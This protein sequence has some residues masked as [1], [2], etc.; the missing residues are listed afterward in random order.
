MIFCCFVGPF[1]DHR[2]E[3]LAKE[4]MQR[5]CKLW[6]IRCLDL[7]QNPRRLADFW[8]DAGRKGLRVSLDPGGLNLDSTAFSKWV[9]KAPHDL[10]FFLWGEKGPDFPLEGAFQSISL[11]P[12]TTSHELARVFFLEQ[13]YRA[14][15]LLRGH[16]YPK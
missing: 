11:S 6:K 8:R 16:P 14:A 10:Y 4:Y 5:T 9:G 1:K 13:L 3:S 12:M 15:C 7:P 2:L